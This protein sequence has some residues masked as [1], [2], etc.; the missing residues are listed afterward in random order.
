MIVE[1][2]AGERLLVLKNV[3]L[4]GGYSLGRGVCGE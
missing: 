1:D 4:G 3:G 2:T